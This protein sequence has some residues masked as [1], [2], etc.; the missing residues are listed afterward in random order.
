MADPA[1]RRKMGSALPEPF[2]AVANLMGGDR[3]ILRVSKH[4]VIVGGSPIHVSRR[5]R[6]R[7]VCLAQNDLFLSGR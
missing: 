6:N 4:G 5:E 7:A 2:H 1:Q 3:T